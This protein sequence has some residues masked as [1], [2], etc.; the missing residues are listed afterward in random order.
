MAWHYTAGLDRE[1][2]S[3][4]FCDVICMSH[5]IEYYAEWVEMYEPL[6]GIG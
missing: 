2:G 6:A 1:H 3:L 4:D 5:W